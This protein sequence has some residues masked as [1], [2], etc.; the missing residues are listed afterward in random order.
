MWNKSVVPKRVVS[1]ALFFFFLLFGNVVQAEFKITYP[2]NNSVVPG[3]MIMV[4]GLGANPQG[5][6]ELKVLTDR[7]YVQD[8]EVEINSNGAWTYGPCHLGGQGQ[9]NNHTIRATII[10][11]GERLE[12]ATV[13]GIVRND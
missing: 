13:R 3:R 12:S 5:T 11:N 1:A 8:G 7:W 10:K 4:E 9:Y 2:K 6:I